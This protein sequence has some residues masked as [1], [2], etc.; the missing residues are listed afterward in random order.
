MS[1]DPTPYTAKAAER[2]ASTTIGK[3]IAFLNL[4]ENQ[5]T[6]KDAPNAIIATNV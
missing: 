2:Q 5:P 6:R 1:E 3:S 4:G